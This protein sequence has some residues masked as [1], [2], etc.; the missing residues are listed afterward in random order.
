MEKAV[1]RDGTTIAYERVGRGPALVLVSGALCTHATEA[2]LAGELADRH[3][4]YVYDRRGRGE[5]GDTA[6]CAV[7]REV[8]DLAAVIEAAGGE[9]GVHGMSSGGALALEAAASGLPITR[10]AVYEVPYSTAPAMRADAGAYTARLGALLAAGDRAGA[11]ELFMGRVGVPPQAVAGMRQSPAWAGLEAVAPTLAYDDAVMGD[12]RVPAARLARI[13]RP[14]LVL[15]GDAGPQWFRDTGRAVAEAVPSGRYG[16]LGGQDH[17][18]APAA[19][20]PV[21]KEFFAGGHMGGTA[22]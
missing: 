16:T 15:C 22:R 13:D 11:V 18:V 9:A 17:Q 21:L 2:P 20:A 12:G 19:L 7:A 6:P 4:V 8:E 10:V 14:V 5:S 1:S 3:T